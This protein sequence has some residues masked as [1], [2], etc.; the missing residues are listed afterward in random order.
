MGR[1]AMRAKHHKS[2]EKKEVRM[3]RLRVFLI[4]VALGLCSA[5]AFAAA[6]F[7]NLGPGR[8]T[9][10]TPDGQVVVA[11]NDATTGNAMI[12][13]SQYGSVTLGA[14]TTAGCA[15]KGSTLV[16]A[17]I[18]GGVAKRWDGNAQGVGSWTSLPLASGSYNW[19]PLRTGANS[20]DVYIGGYTTYGGYDRATRYKESVN[21][22]TV[23]A[24]PPNGRNPSRV[25]GVASNQD[26][27]AGQANY[28]PSDGSG[29][30]NAWAGQPGGTSW[31][32]YTFS[33]PPSTSQ[34]ARIV[35]VSGNGARMVGR[36]GG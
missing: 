6:Q 30:Y 3:L 9:G 34:T 16:V 4:A 10:M 7:I 32:Y 5:G 11:Y 17:G 35:A 12:W 23:L 2:K 29:A 36:S 18:V 24:L 22:S 8:T 26:L 25:L 15:W 14:G 13:S 31:W 1:F 27:F 21:S 33:G 20:N 19:T 28:G